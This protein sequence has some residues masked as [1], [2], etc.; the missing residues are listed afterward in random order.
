MQTHNENF[1]YE[2]L[3]KTIKEKNPRIRISCN[4]M[5]TDQRFTRSIKSKSRS[6]K[7]RRFEQLKAQAIHIQTLI[8]QK[9]IEAPG[10]KKPWWQFW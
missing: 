5:K 9:S 10:V 6:T 7:R 4:Y 8:N 3:S 1:G 2:N